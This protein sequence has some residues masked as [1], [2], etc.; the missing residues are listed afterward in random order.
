MCAVG[1]ICWNVID[2]LKMPEIVESG[3]KQPTQCVRTKAK[4]ELN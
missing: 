1:V 4:D 2:I 3:I